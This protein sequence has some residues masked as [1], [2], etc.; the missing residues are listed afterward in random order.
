PRNIIPTA[1]I[2]FQVERVAR[3]N[4]F[5]Q[6]AVDPRDRGKRLYVTWS[7]YRNGDVDVFCSTS[8]NGGR[9]WTPAQRVNNDPVHD[10]ADQFFQW[11]AVDPTD[12]AVNVMFYDRRNDPTNR[13]QIVVLARS[14]DGGKNFINYA[15]TQKPFDAYRG[16]LGDYTGLAAMN[17]RVYGAWPIRPTKARGN[18]LQ[19]GVADFSEAGAQ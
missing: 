15:W 6:I 14:T 12:G 10:G 8:S 17:G 3:S 19:V 2:M 7:D 11:L 4:G 18:I 16:F 5:P 1:P 9:T 13:S